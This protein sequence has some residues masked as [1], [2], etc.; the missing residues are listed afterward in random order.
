MNEFIAPTI[1]F[2]FVG[3]SFLFLGFKKL[4][5]YYLI[6]NIPTSKIRSIAL[7]LVEVFG[8]IKVIDTIKTPISKKD[9]V[10]YRLVVEKRVPSSKTSKWKK[11]RDEIS[12]ELFYIKDETGLIKI[13]P[14]KI[15][16]YLTLKKVYFF[17]S[18]LLK[19]NENPL[20]NLKETSIKNGKPKFELKF[21]KNGDER[22][23]EYY[24]EENNDVYVLAKAGNQEN[25]SKLFLYKGNNNEYFMIGDSDENTLLKKIIKKISF[26][27]IVSGF[28]LIIVF[29]IFLPIIINML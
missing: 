22:Y 29:S 16:S 8:K 15:E 4:K 3:I 26:C 10:F 23:F 25:S 20:D 13:N 14:Y 24:L 12:C 28:L 5:E 19:L 6:K 1:F 11:I 27:F 9:C 18:N 7:G 17:S 21:I 2:G